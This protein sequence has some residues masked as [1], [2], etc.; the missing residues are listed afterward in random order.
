MVGGSIYA[1]GGKGVRSR[2][3]RYAARPSF[4]QS[5]SPYLSVV[6]RHARKYFMSP[7]YAF[8]NIEQLVLR[9]YLKDRRL[10]RQARGNDDQNTFL[11]YFQTGLS[12]RE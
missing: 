7:T 5:V 1:K 9:S 12:V 3:L 11:I 2:C 4:S 6:L 10:L 8:T